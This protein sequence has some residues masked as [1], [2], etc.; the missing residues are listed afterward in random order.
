MAAVTRLGLE[1]YGVRRAG[2]FGG[3]TPDVPSMHPVGII[4]RLGAEGYGVRRV[5]AGGFAGK[6]PDSG[7]GSVGISEYIYFCRHKGRR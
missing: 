5:V 2:S 7:G 3:K 1:G 6:T 4:T